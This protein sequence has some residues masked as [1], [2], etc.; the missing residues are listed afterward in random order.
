MDYIG[1]KEKLQKTLSIL[2]NKRWTSR[3]E[4][5]RAAII[6][7]KDFFFKGSLPI[8][9][10]DRTN[11]SFVLTDYP[12]DP[13]GLFAYFFIF[14]EDKRKPDGYSDYLLQVELEELIEPKFWTME[15]MELF[16]YMNHYAAV[17]H[18]HS[19]LL[20]EKELLLKKI[21]RIDEE[22]IFIEATLQKYV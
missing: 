19:T 11:I 18:N 20:Q 22:L 1:L 3:D 10:A 6:T 17:L 14:K 16:E 8:F 21:G 13:K 4:L 7:V 12:L 2:E 5:E 9:T 15:I